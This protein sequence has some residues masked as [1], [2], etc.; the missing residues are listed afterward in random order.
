M[1]KITATILLSL[2]AGSVC[3]DSLF[4][5][6]ITV[7]NP[8]GGASQTKDFQSDVAKTFFADI[9]DKNIAS[10]FSGYNDSWA[11]SSQDK[12]NGVAITGSFAAGSKVLKMNMPGIGVN[13]LTFAGYSRDNSV[14]LMETYIRNNT[15]GIYTKMLDYQIGHTGSSQVSGNP[16]SLVGLSVAGTFTDAVNLPI[17]GSTTASTSSAPHMAAM[18][19]PLFVGVTGGTY[20]QGGHTP[21]SV[22]NVPIRSSFGVDSNDPRKKVLINGQFSYITVNQASS[23]Q[24]HFG[25]GYMHPINDNWYLIPNFSYGIIGSSDLATAGQILSTSLSSNY[26]FKFR[27]V[28][29]GLVNMFA[30]YTSLPLTIGGLV[31]S[32]PNIDSYVFKNGI[33]PSKVFNVYGHDVRIKGIFTDTEFTGSK[34]FIRQYN[35]L[36]LE[37]SSVKPLKWLGTATKGFVDSLAFSAKYVFSIENPNNFEGY[38]LGLS[39]DF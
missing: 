4:D 17:H 5:A 18:G 25:V 29:M 32:N 11:V 36:G 19:N 22:F 24:G 15:N 6:L 20:T 26:Q 21:I 10:S 12:F 3:A 14:K 34:V 23:Y 13:N 33:F 8:K 38:D 9:K 39:Y 1:K 28:D 7:T 35:E 27:G 16:T 31:N 37:F 2:S 30:Y